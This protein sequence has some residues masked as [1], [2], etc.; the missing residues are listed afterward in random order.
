MKENTELQWKLDLKEKLYHELKLKLDK[1]LDE[2]STLLDK[3]ESEEKS[4][5][6]LEGI[7]KDSKGQAH[8]KDK[9]YSK[10]IN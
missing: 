3:V 8:R 2:N 6:E 4:K 9:Y 7:A 1:L 10:I 5:T